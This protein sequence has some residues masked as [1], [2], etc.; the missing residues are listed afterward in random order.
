VPGRLLLTGHS[1]GAALATLAASVVPADR[2]A[3]TLLCTFG[4]PRVGDETFGASLGGLTHFRYAGARDLVTWVPPIERFIPYRHHGILRCIDATGAMR[5]F[6]ADEAAHVQAASLRGQGH[7][8][9]SL[10]AMFLALVARE[11]P[12]K[13]LADHAPINYTSAV[14][15]LR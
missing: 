9:A 13:E 15:G 7:S 1:L 4:S 12:A 5:E 2:R 14:W 8:Q 10:L 3:Q 6:R 11:V